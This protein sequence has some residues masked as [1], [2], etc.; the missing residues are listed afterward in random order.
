MV[1]NDSEEYEIVEED[2]TER[3]EQNRL[4]IKENYTPYVEL[5]INFV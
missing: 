1:V 3:K 2:E 4:E 5:S